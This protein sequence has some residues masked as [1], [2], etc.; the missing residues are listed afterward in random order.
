MRIQEPDKAIRA[1]ESALAIDPDDSSLASRIGKAYVTTHDYARAVEYY[2]SAAK[3]SDTNRTTLSHELAHLY[4][5]LK[6]YAEAVRV[7]NNVLSTNKLKDRHG[8]RRRGDDGDGGDDGGSERV[9]VAT[10]RDDVRTHVLLAD[11]HAGMD[12]QVGSITHV[13]SGNHHL[14]CLCYQ[15]LS[16]SLTHS[17]TLY[18]FLF[19]PHLP[20]PCQGAR[21]SSLSQAYELQGGVLARLRRERPDEA[22]DEALG[23]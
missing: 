3:K 4:I 17:L 2:E 23:E 22:D 6:Y 13:A 14:S 8:G 10:L 15:T 16:H 18:S 20:L 11:V 21:A 19:L 7:L 9:D 5:Q 1:Y 12:D